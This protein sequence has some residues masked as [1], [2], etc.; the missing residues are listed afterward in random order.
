M[1]TCTICLLLLLLLFVRLQVE[2][3]CCLTSTTPGPDAEH[4]YVIAVNY[5]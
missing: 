4:D 2:Q 1:L 5:W 3:R